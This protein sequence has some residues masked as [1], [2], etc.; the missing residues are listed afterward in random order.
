MVKIKVPGIDREIEFNLHDPIESTIPLFL[1]I[2]T[3]ESSTEQ[4]V[5]Q[6]QML[7]AERV[8]NRQTVTAMAR[9]AHDFERT[10]RQ[11]IRGRSG[12][13]RQVTS[14]T[15]AE[16]IAIVVLYCESI[17]HRQAIRRTLEYWEF[18]GQPPPARRLIDECLRRLRSWSIPD[19]R[20]VADTTRKRY[21]G[22][23]GLPKKSHTKVRSPN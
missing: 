1:A 17:G 22:L 6:H 3:M 8:P 10:R 4:Y 7:I 18:T 12:R 21:A 23:P 9:N 20:L 11:Q 15:Q 5:D 14:F 19:L 2:T 16:D 13:P